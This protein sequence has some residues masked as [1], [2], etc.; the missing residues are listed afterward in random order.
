MTIVRTTA[1]SLFGRERDVAALEAFV[2]QEAGDGS[3]VLVTGEAGVG[4]TAV[5]DVVA[6]GA[7]QR[8][9][10]VLRA[11]GTE[12]EAALSFAGLNQLLHPVLNGLPGLEEADRRAL[13]VALGL[14][15]GRASDEFAV[16]QATVRLLAHLTETAPD[17][18]VVDD[19][20]WLDRAS[21]AVLAYVA[22]R[23]A[24]TRVALIA[25][26]RSGERT[27]FERGGIDQHELQPLSEPEASA[28]LEARFPS[29]TLHTRG[30]LIAEAQGNPLALLELPIAL[31]IRRA[32]SPSLPRV[33]PLTERLERLFASRLDHLPPASREALLLAV[34]DGTGELSV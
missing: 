14:G 5:V 6:A 20:N 9:V 34:L 3:A 16:A 10:R 12:F 15:E 28:L 11:A 32:T 31:N 30:R 22:R 13:R 4:K 17:L 18:V 25:T 21:S 19:A 1:H 24:G 33:L 23:V 7:R 8:G 2:A 29:L 27:P 26:M